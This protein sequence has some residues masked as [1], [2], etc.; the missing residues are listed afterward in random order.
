MVEN[1]PNR[2]VLESV[3]KEGATGG[4]QA[5]K[6]VYLMQ[7]CTN[8][9]LYFNPQIPHSLPQINSTLD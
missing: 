6:S 8:Q 2:L 4:R 1:A 5:L 3:N 9:E 7:H